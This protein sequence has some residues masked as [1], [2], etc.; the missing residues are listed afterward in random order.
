MADECDIFFAQTVSHFW[1]VLHSV[2]EIHGL[3]PGTY[4][5]STI[6]EELGSQQQSVTVTAHQ[7]AEANFIYAGH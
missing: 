3:P 7:T 6:Q 1:G 2:Y 5:L 4:V